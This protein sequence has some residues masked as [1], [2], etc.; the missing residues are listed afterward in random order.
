[1]K[2]IDVVVLH[3]SHP[4]PANMM[5]FGATLTQRGHLFKTGD[6][7]KKYYNECMDKEYK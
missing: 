4:K 1:M 3:E 7:L 5:M 2:N 6:D